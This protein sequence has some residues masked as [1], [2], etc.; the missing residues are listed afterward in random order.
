MEHIGFPNRV[1][2]NFIKW[3]VGSGWHIPFCRNDKWFTNQWLPLIDA[4]AWLDQSAL[5]F[6]VAKRNL[7]LWTMPEIA[8]RSVRWVKVIDQILKLSRPH[9]SCKLPVIQ[10]QIRSITQDT[11]RTSYRMSL[12]STW[13]K[14]YR[15]LSLD[16]AS[17]KSLQLTLFRKVD[18]C[19]VELRF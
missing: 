4:K 6:L 14:I 10:S 2:Y 18:G 17:F 7:L 5:R 12:Y 16:V 8:I 1:I 15:T 11:R 3:Q 19:S 9:Y 13:N